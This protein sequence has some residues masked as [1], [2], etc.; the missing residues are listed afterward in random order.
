MAKMAFTILLLLLTQS[1]YGH[2]LLTNIYVDGID[3]GD[4]KC[5]RM[6]NNI[7][8]AT[9]PISPSTDHTVASAEMACGKKTFLQFLEFELTKIQVSTA[10]KVLPGSAPSKQ[11]QA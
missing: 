10:R 1:I 4:G 2:T 11:G 5:V 6:S 3:Q 8:Q 9:W 7:P